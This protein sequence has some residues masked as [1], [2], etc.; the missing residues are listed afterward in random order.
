M[1]PA[2]ESSILQNLALVASR[3]LL[4]GSSHVSRK[5]PLDQTALRDPVKSRRTYHCAQLPRFLF[6]CQ[7]FHYSS[8]YPTVSFSKCTV[9]FEARLSSG[10]IFR[11][12]VYW[13]MCKQLLF[14]L[15]S[16]TAFEDINSFS[17]VL[18]Y[19]AINND[20]TMLANRIGFWSNENPI[21]YNISVA[22]RTF[23]HKLRSGK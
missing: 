7:K 15:P 10:E 1:S 5:A 20:S 17:V 22:H 19:D 23:N 18:D 14:Y 11:L 8:A 2:L 16:T 21:A 4:L 12:F 13:R 3:L 6:K 9:K